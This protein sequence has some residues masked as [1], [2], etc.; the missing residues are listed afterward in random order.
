MAET[1]YTLGELQEIRKRR[2]NRLL[3][4]YVYFLGFMVCVTPIN[5]ALAPETPWFVIPLVLGG[6]P[7]AVLTA[8]AM[9]IFGPPRRR[10]QGS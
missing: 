8:Q 2:R 10:S 1:D 3:N 6:A 9:E 7:L 5:A 4:L